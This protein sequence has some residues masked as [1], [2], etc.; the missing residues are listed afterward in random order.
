MPSLCHLFSTLFQ[1]FFFLNW[2]YKQQRTIS[3]LRSPGY[4][5]KD[6]KHVPRCESSTSLSSSKAHVTFS[7]NAFI[8]S[9]LELVQS[10]YTCLWM[11]KHMN[12]FIHKYI[13]TWIY[14]IYWNK[15]VPKKIFWKESISNYPRIIYPLHFPSTE[16][17][18]H[19][20]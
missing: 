12:T 4:L 18:D 1:S 17:N 3:I 19:S 20:V 6:D 13:N 8:L 15:Y 2:W 11:Y 5:M 10:L 7:Y 16:I 14:F 9:I